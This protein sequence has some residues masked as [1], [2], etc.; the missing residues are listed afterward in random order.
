MKVAGRLAFVSATVNEA[1][2]TVRVHMELANPRGRYKPAM[3]ATMLLQGRTAP[4][5]CVPLT[6]IVREGD[7]ESVFVQ[8]GP[9][10]FLLR[11]VTLGPE[12]G[13]RRVIREG[14]ASAETIVLDGAFHLNNERRRRSVRGSE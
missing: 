11:P 7:R 8:T 12:Y 9:R 2:R 6:A 3:L 10:N 5:P 4:A 14:V 13:G 1:T